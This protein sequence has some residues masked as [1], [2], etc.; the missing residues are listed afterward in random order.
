MTHSS[1]RFAAAIEALPYEVR[2]HA[3][4][5]LYAVPLKH[6]E[7]IVQVG[8]FLPGPMFLSHG[9]VTVS[10]VLPDGSEAVICFARPR[11]WVLGD[12]VVAGEKPVYD[13]FAVGRAEVIVWPRASFIEAHHASPA[14]Q[15]LVR[16][17]GLGTQQL[18]LR[19][20]EQSLVLTLPQRLARRLLELAELVG[21][22]MED[23]SIKLA[24]PVSHALL[25]SSLGVTRQ[26]IH[27]QLR[28]WA[29]LG[30]LESRYRDVIL[31]SLP[32]LRK[33]GTPS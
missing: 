1:T 26:R 15:E 24:A 30:W 23:G 27:G 20:L 8:V 7:K 31:H 10:R 12:Q 19:E 2:A 9:A 6:G 13:G 5:S 14:L 4:R 25:A 3:A 16:Q 33:I 28:D 18:I 17:S 22:P 11:I 29:E 32:E 21:K